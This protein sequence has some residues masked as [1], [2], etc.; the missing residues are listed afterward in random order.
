MREYRTDDL[1]RGRQWS[2]SAELTPEAAAYLQQL[3]EAALELRVTK[4]RRE[5]DAIIN[6]LPLWARCAVK[7]YVI[8]AQLGRGVRRYSLAIVHIIRRK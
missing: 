6:R 3:R 1:L 7:G 2:A 5:V 8:T 4:L